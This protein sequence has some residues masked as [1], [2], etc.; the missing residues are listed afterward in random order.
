MIRL[1]EK[2]RRILGEKDQVFLLLSTE[3]DTTKPKKRRENRDDLRFVWNISF[4]V[5]IIVLMTR[6][7]FHDFIL[8]HHDYSLLCLS[9]RF[10]SFMYLT[11]EF[12]CDSFRHHHGSLVSL[13]FH[14]FFLCL[15]QTSSAGVSLPS[16]SQ[17][18]RSSHSVI[19]KNERG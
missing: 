8:P 5:M 19:Q 15:L 14:L 2:K 12:D 1:E 4:L 9:S 13:P 7:L 6:S 17:C 3:E 11:R 10:W 16:V 18:L